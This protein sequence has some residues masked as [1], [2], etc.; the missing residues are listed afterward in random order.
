MSTKK[1]VT[2]QDILNIL[3]DFMLLTSDKILKR[4]EYLEDVTVK[5]T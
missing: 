2:N 5:I 4:T 1:R 3:Q